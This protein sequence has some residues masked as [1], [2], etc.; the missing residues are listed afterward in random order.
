MQFLR[1][2]PDTLRYS[3]FL[4]LADENLKINKHN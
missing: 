4:N 3:A 1:V 2:A